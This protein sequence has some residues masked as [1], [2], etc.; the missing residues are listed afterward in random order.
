MNK[1][2]SLAAL[3]AALVFVSGSAQIVRADD[4]EIYRNLQPVESAEPFVMFSI[5]LRSNVMNETVCKGSECDAFIAAGWL[6]PVGPYSRFDLYRAALNAVLAPLSGVKIGLMLNHAD[7]NKSEC[8][9]GPP[10]RTGCSNGGYIAMGFN[11]LEEEDGNGTKAMFREILAS[12]PSHAN[13]PYQGRELFFEFLS[14]LK[15]WPVWNSFN[16][17]QSFDDNTNSAN[18]NVDPEHSGRWNDPLTRPVLHGRPLVRGFAPDLEVIEGWEIEDQNAGTYVGTYQNRQGTYRSPLGPN[19]ECAKIFTINFMFGVSQQDDGP[20]DS[21]EEIQL[22]T[23]LPDKCSAGVWGQQCQFGTMINHLHTADVAPDVEGHQGVTS[24]F[25]SQP[26]RAGN[27]PSGMGE[28]AKWGGTVA[29]R[30][31]SDDPEELVAV[32]TEIIKEILSIS[33]TFTAAALPVNSFDRS[34]V[35]SDVFLALFQPTE[36]YANRYWWGN[37]KKLKLQGID[38]IGE[39]VALVDANDQ[40]AIAADGRIRFDALTY[41]TDPNGFDVQTPERDPDENAV[42]GKDGRSVNRGGAGQRIPDFLGAGP[43]MQNSPGPRRMF[44]D[45][46]PSSL[47]PLDATESV[48]SLLLADIGA[49]SEAEAL[50]VIKFMRGGTP[51]LEL[52]E[53]VTLEWM[54]GSAMHSR[55]LPVNYGARGLHSEQNPLIYVAAG[56]NDGALRFIRNTDGSG[57]QLGREAWAFVPTEVMDN[58][59]RTVRGGELLTG[60][61]TVYGFDG[62]PTLYVE[63]DVDGTIVEDSTAIIYAGLRRGGSAYYAIDVSDPENPELLWRIVGGENPSHPDF[64]GLALTFSQ[65]RVGKANVGAKGI[66]PVVV[67]GGGYDRIYDQRSV[68]PGGGDNGIKGKGIYVVDA[69]TGELIKH[70]THEEMFDSIPSNVTAVDTTNDGLL[71]RIYVGDLGGRVWR[72]DMAGEPSEWMASILADVGRHAGNDPAGGSSDRRFF[73]APDVVLSKTQYQQVDGTVETVEFDAVLIGSGDREN[74]LDQATNP[75]PENWFFM[76]RDYNTAA[77]STA[78][79]EDPGFPSQYI[80]GNFMDVTSNTGELVPKGGAGWALQLTVPG[81]KS[82]ATPLTLAGRVYFTT[83]LPPGPG[84]AT[85]CGPAEG[86]GR[87][88]TVSLQNANPPR[89]LDGIIVDTDKLDPDLRFDPLKSGGI[90]AEVVLIPQV[91]KVMRPDFELLTPPFSTRWRTYWYVQED[92]VQ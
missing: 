91:G 17:F 52:D 42:V 38:P 13:H 34:Q 6:P 62:P 28:Y 2:P 3:A 50:D 26:N 1:H 79:V 71:D 89:N 25:L 47:A 14:Y 72:I 78:D 37:I 61:S 77:L 73:H 46:G 7:S 5:D 82:L 74:P 58:V 24:Y 44:Y 76:I 10:T 40:P 27:F 49:A 8:K 9:S 36:Q 67:F 41:W 60:E 31:L 69:K 75:R 88:Y 23:G 30:A 86:S 81:E 59:R 80:L 11:S 39:Q 18:I 29:P 85:V 84:S 16:G 48:A 53:P 87:L 65:P 68:V 4:A 92:P 66:Q 56:S 90:P 15:G 45:S 32:L 22:R 54:F 51:A 20:S 57:N 64:A 35:L 70:I 43:G 63:G 83:Y 19:N 21:Q 33:T 55:P 12:I